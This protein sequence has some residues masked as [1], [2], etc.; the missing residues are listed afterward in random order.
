MMVDVLIV[1]V[2]SVDLHGRVVV[3]RLPRPTIVLRLKF[4]SPL[5]FTIHENGERRVV[6]RVDPI[7]VHA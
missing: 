7:E 2:L 4:V 6:F 3:V 1:I 5:R